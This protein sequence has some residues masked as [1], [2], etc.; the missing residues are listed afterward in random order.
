MILIVLTIHTVILALL[1]ISNFT[2][3]S[4]LPPTKKPICLSDFIDPLREIPFVLLTIGGFIAFFGIFIPIGYVVVAA[5]SVG[6]SPRLQN[7]IVPC[8]Y[9]PKSASAMVSID[10]ASRSQCRQYHRSYS[11]RCT[12]RQ[13]WQVQHVHHHVSA[14]NHLRL[15]SMGSC[16]VKCP[17]YSL[18]LLLRLQLR[19]LCLPFPSTHC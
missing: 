7:Y 5:S 18:R 15:C 19:C 10:I 9:C 17:H 4:R 8:Q 6:M 11:P 16:K 2:I 12:C 13:D 14:I 1:M 3:T